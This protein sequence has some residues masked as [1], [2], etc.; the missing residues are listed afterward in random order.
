MSFSWVHPHSIPEFPGNFGIECRRVQGNSGI[1]QD[2]FLY[3]QA[4]G[5]QQSY[6]K[7]IPSLVASF[8]QSTSPFELLPSPFSLN[9]IF[10]KPQMS[11]FGPLPFERKPI[12]C[13]AGPQRGQTHLNRSISNASIYKLGGMGGL[14]LFPDPNLQESDV[15]MGVIFFEILLY[16]DNILYERNM[17]IYII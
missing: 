10:Y 13:L 15:Q 1:L 8:S 5:G 7:M 3:F 12:F 4:S 14:A 2:S 11:I 9:F 6:L 16:G 17:Y